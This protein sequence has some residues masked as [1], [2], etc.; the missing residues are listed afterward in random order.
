MH[1]CKNSL[2]ECVI[3]IL[4]S[5][6]LTL[7]VEESPVKSGGRSRVSRQTL[8]ELNLGEGELVVLSSNKKDILVT[9]Y[10]DNLIR[11][12]QIKIRQQDLRKLGVKEGDEVKLKQHQSLLTNLL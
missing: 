4:M 2:L 6:H 1:I 3:F 8:Q 10:C 11:N 5:N 9:L 7:K 12:G